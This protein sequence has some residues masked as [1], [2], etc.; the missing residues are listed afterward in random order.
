MCI[1][2]YGPVCAELPF[3][4]ELDTEFKTISNMCRTPT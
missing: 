3:S 1:K 2:L 4:A